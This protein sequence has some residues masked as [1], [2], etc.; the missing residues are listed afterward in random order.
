MFLRMEFL[1]SKHSFSFNTN[2]LS[3]I[4]LHCIFRY[5][6]D[7]GGRRKRYSCAG[8][9]MQFYEEAG[10]EEWWRTIRRLLELSRTYPNVYS[11]FVSAPS[12]PVKK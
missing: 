2:G 9:Y 4:P 6:G 10:S 7:S 8:S 1:E 12:S 5:K 11:T 3:E